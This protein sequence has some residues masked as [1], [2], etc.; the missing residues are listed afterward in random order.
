[1][2][3]ADQIVNG[4]ESFRVFTACPAI[5][6]NGARS[7]V[8]CWRAGFHDVECV[9]AEELFVFKVPGSRFKVVGA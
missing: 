4:Y 7:A 5:F 8:S 1:M 3:L 6:E 2:E 9:P